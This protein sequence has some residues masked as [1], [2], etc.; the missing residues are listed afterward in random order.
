MRKTTEKQLTDFMTTHSAYPYNS[1][2]S[3]AQAIYRAVAGHSR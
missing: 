2:L 1:L 3:E